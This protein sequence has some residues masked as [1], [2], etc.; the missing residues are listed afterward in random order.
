MYDWIDDGVCRACVCEQGIH[1][2]LHQRSDV[3]WSRSAK[4]LWGMVRHT[5][6]V[7]ILHIERDCS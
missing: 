3:F 5:L 4:L 6:L 7:V 1:G 2:W